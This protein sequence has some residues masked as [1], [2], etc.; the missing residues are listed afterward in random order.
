VQELSQHE[1]QGDLDNAERVAIIAFSS[2]DRRFGFNIREGGSRG[3]HA[4]PTKAK[5]RAARLK[6]I[7]T[8]EMYQKGADKRRGLVRS[9]EHRAKLSAIHKGKP[10]SEEV[11]AKMSESALMRVASGNHPFMQGKRH[12]TGRSK[13][14]HLSEE[15]K[16]TISEAQKLRHPPDDQVS[17]ETLSSRERQRRYRA[18]KKALLG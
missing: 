10:K 11:R 6:Q 15:Q 4:E 17:A 8:P 3:R 12:V 1:T 14:F 16:K 2:Q 13:G 9:V 7:I 5:L 18:R